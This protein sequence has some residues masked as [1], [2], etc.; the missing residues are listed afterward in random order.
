[1]VPEPFELLSKRQD[2]TDTWT[3]ELAACSGEPLEFDPGQFT[4]L[5]AFGAG[6][7]PFFVMPGSASSTACVVILP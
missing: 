2:T 5:S 3:L 4:M 6:S 1:M 7:S